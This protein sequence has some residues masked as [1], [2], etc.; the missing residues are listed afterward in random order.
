MGVAF[1]WAHTASASNHRISTNVSG[2]TPGRPPF[3]IALRSSMGFIETGLPLCP[4]EKKARKL[5]HEI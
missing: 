1:S 3:G 5:A 2:L 4:P